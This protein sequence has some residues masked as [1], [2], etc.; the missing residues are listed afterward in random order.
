MGLSRKGV[1]QIEKRALKKSRLGRPQDGLSACTQATGQLRGEE[2]EIVA[3]DLKKRRK[4]ITKHKHRKFV[5]TKRHKK[6]RT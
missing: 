3:N 4:K 5:K 2:V 6:K 1:R